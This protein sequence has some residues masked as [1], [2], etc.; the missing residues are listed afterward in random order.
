M[1]IH[2]LPTQL[3]NQIAAGEVVERPSSVVKELVENS[4]DA[5]AG[6][7]HIE[8][9]QGG[10]RLIKIRDDGC[11]IVKDDLPL[12]LSRHATSKIASL[13]DLEQ[14]ASMGFRGEA[15]PSIS[16]VS[17]LT[18]ISRTAAS[19][20][21]WRVA[22]DGSE[23]DF[24]PQPDPH[25]PGTTIE[26]RDL[27]Y[28]TPARRKFLKTEKTEFNH[29][30]TLLQRMAL[31]R[32][33]IGLTLVHNQKEIFKLKPALSEAQQIQRVASL[34]GHAFV[35]N[36]VSID[37]AAAGLQLTGWVGLPTFSRSQQDMQFFYVNRRLIKDK[38]VAHAVKQ[39]YQDVLF[40][41]RHPVFVLYLTLD[42]TL[43][44][45]NAHPAKLE[46]RFRE[47]RLVH[48]FLFSA[49][50]RSLADLR[51]GHPDLT[52][53]TLPEVSHPPLPP[54]VAAT[55]GGTAAVYQPPPA[56]Q[57][58]L[59][60]QVEEQLRHYAQLAAEPLPIPTAVDAEAGGAP[61]LGY[62]IAHLHN[63]F[64]L[65]ETRTGIILVDAHAAH[66]RVTYERLK[67][68]Y[69]QGTVASQ[70]LLLPIKLSTSLA[71]A[72]L[73]EQA[74]AIFLALGFD[75]NRFGPETIVLRAVPALLRHTDV[76]TL[77]RDVLADLS[78]H[79]MSQRV[80]EHIQE[81]LATMACHGAVRAQ[82]RLTVEEMNGLLRDMEKTERSGQ[83]N[84][85]RP[86]WIA[87]S[88]GELD[89]FFL[90]GQ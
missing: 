61:P 75:I 29:I 32:F 21:A 82:R 37:F 77:F 17:R 18:L 73:A 42:P 55:G 71:E 56:K 7:I 85:G 72:D 36:A 46:V 38:L 66:E 14:V 78:E 39:A 10:I 76:E 64:I 11:G 16:S 65:S 84:H 27:F 62:A 89:K 22:A 34:C 30:E 88:T 59:P 6:H 1:R 4:F 90:R 60:L 33:D 9:E 19:D 15:L 20:C 13:Q 53:H 31:S 24:A 50:H 51:P 67:Q 79:G 81:L 3:V 74:Q 41:G 2:P 63:I 80:Q 40:H 86:T 54:T 70:P 25:P 69:Q 26:V 8:I 49:L 48:D 52:I 12:A 58:Q 68:Q 28:N 35:D 47:G 5:G 45:V 83:C 43:V 87:L 57:S 23:Q 44:D